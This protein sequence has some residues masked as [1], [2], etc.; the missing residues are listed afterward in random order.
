MD[1]RERHA[2]QSRYEELLAQIADFHEKDKIRVPDIE[3]CLSFDRDSFKK[4]LID[5]CVSHNQN[6][7]VLIEKDRENFEF[8]RFPQ[9]YPVGC[10]TANL[11]LVAAALR[12]ADI[13]DFDRERTP[14]VLFYYLV[15]T[16]LSAPTNVSALEWSKHLAI[17]NWEINPEVITFKGRCS[18]HVVH[19][20]IVQFVE[21]IRSEIVATQATFR[22][23][24]KFCMVVWAT[25]RCQGRNCLRRVQLHT[26][27]FPTG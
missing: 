2:T 19:H 6:A 3:H 23:G 20:A 18:S 26:I 14:S 13:L 16:A 27:S 12:L 21:A 9:S 24:E 10:A 4:K 11:H 17:S 22:L 7:E 1:T 15:P 8:P 5:V 25:R